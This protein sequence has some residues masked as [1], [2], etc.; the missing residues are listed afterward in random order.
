MKNQV[1]ITPSKLT[2]TILTPPSKSMSHRAIICA[3]LS[4]ET[5]V[6]SNLIF[7][8]DIIA[9][10]EAMEQFGMVV[11]NKSEKN[12]RFELTLSNPKI[13]AYNEAGICPITEAT[14]IQCNES[15]S[16]IRFL[17]PMIHLSHAA[18]TFSGE[19][20]LAQRPYQTYY[21]IFEDQKIKFETTN[22]ELPVTI[23]GALKSGLYQLEG[24]VSSQFITGLMLTLPMLHG[25]SEIEITTK[26][27]SKGYVDLT[28]N[29][30]E[31]FG[32]EIDAKDEC[33]Y[34]INGEQ[35]Y[36]GANYTVEGDYSQAAFWIVAKCIGN[37]VKIRGMKEA[38]LQGDKA[39]LDIVR[40]MGAEVGFENSDI[41]ISLEKPL[42]GI[43]IDA[44]QCPDLVPVVAVLCSLCEGESKIINAERLRLKES[45]RLLAIS[46][47]LNKMG[48]QIVETPDGL[49]IQGVKKFNGANVESW[50]DHRIAMALGIAATRAD[51]NLVIDGSDAVKK[52]YPNFWEDYKSLGGTFNE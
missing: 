47:E 25:K 15:G 3:G 23:K 19:G 42:Q 40:N 43:V 26:L 27:E 9:T 30:L 2:G 10:T 34:L 18:L 39:I 16:T 52:S 20:R 21:S 48:A 38:S 31:Q 33:H 35:T 13:R 45:D 6:I 49:I 14:T 51:G 12:D 41:I 22:G 50:N 44:S 36:K 37:N 1:S 11:G 46:T 32:V 4:S 7:S 28:L 29:M 17:M 24:N 8:N 5:S